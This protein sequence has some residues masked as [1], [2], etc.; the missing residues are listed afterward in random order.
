MFR[1]CIRQEYI[2]ALRHC[3]VMVPARRPRIESTEAKGRSHVASFV[4]SAQRNS[5]QLIIAREE[6]VREYAIF[7]LHSDL[8]FE[9]PPPPPHT[10][11]AVMYGL[12]PFRVRL[13]D[14]F[15]VHICL[16]SSPP[17]SRF[18]RS[19]DLPV[20]KDRCV[21]LFELVQVTQPLPHGARK[22]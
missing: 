10:A 22:F 7:A 6:T 1:I 3:K 17:A 20:L 18:T 2:C 13:R 19:C 12:S 21:L 5:L 14:L 11:F 15:L 8:L 4:A 9:W 16:G